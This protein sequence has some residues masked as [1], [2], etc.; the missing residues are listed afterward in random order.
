LPVLADRDPTAE[1]EAFLPLRGALL[2]LISF[3]VLNGFYFK[4]TEAVL[5]RVEHERLALEGG[6]RLV[7]RV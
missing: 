2:E 1:I 5:A 6:L 3:F 7:L 4:G